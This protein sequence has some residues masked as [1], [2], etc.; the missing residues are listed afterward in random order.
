MKKYLLMADRLIMAA[1]GIGLVLRLWLQ[2]VGPDEKGLFPAGHISWLLLLVLTGCVAVGL[3]LLAGYAG[4][5]RSYRSNFPASVPG[6]IGCAIGAV[7]VAWSSLSSLLESAGTLQ[8][9]CSFAGV[10]AAVAL[11]FFGWCRFKDLRPNGFTFG[12]ICLYLGIRVFVLGRLWG[13][14][15]ELLRFLFGFLATVCTMLAG[16]QL[17]GFAVELGNRSASLLWSGLAIFLC[18]SAVGEGTDPILYAGLAVWLLLN[19]CPLKVPPRAPRP[20]T[21]AEAPAEAPAAEAPTEE[22]TDEQLRDILLAADLTATDEGE[23]EA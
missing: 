3:F 5:N 16:Y 15:P 13:D 14:D 12:L 19:L 1:G 23:A 7:C 8:T 6:A 17:W 20:A 2:L 9:V 4:R 18:C 22:L 11:A 10:A 21:A